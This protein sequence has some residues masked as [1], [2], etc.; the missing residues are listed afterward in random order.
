MAERGRPK[1][2]LIPSDV[3][4]ETLLRWSRRAKTSQALALQAKMVLAVLTART[5]RAS[6]RG[7]E[8]GRRRWV[9]AVR[10][11]PGLTVGLDALLD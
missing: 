1:P 3:E 10:H 8:S 2:A 11:R 5:T 6:R 7:W 9:R 4:R